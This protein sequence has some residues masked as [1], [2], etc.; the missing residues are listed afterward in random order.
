MAK[1]IKIIHYYKKITAKFI[2]IPSHSTIDGNEKADVHDK[3][4]A[5]SSTELI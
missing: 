2:W 4:V 1:L 3:I 5:S